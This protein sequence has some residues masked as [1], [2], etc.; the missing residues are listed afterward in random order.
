VV[1]NLVQCVDY[2]DWNRTIKKK[3]TKKMR[4]RRMKGTFREK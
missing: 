2:G 1:V 3:D 4:R